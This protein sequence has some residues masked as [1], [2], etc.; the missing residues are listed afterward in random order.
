M[1]KIFFF[2]LAAA[3][4][5][6]V[7][8]QSANSFTGRI[9]DNKSGEPI[10]G[11]TVT[12]PDLKLKL[13]SDMLGNFSFPAGYKGQHMVEFSGLGYQTQSIKVDFNVKNLLSV[14]LGA[15]HVSLDEIIVTT[16]IVSSSSRRNSTSITVVDKQQL[17]EP[18]TNIIDALAK[19]APGVAAIT[20]GSS[21]AKPVIRGLSSNRVVTINNGI[22]QQGNQW[23]DEHG[24]EVDQYGA[25]RVEILRGAASLMYGSDA[26]GGVI[27]FLEPLVPENG[28]IKGELLSNYSTNAGLTS[29]SAMLTGNRNG[30]VWRGRGTYKNA[31]SFKT[32]RGYFPNSGFNETNISA[33]LGLNKSWGYSHINASFF[34]N[35]IGFY[36]P[37]FDAQ[38]NY[39]DADGMPFTRPDY[40]NRRLA[41]P[42]QDIRHYKLSWNNQLH[43]NAGTLKLDM[44]YQNNQRREMDNP[45]PNLFLDL[46]TF[47]MDAKYSLNEM[48]GWQPVFGVS[49]DGSQNVNKGA[50]FLLPDY[51]SLGTGTFAYLKKSW[52]K[53]TANAGVRYDYRFTKGEPYIKEDEAFDR[54]KNDFSNVSFALGLTHQ[55]NPYLNVKMNIGNAFRSP[56]PAELSSNGEHEGTFRYEIGSPNLKPEKS[57]Q[58]DI[59][60]D[61][62]RGVFSGSLSVYT[63]FINDYIYISSKPGDETSSG[64]AIYRYGQVDAQLSGFEGD[65]NL[66]ILPVLTF[67]NLFSYTYAKNKTLD[68]PLPFIPAGRIKNGLKFSPSF[69][70][71]NGSY[72]K[73]GIDNFL[74]QNRVD[75]EFETAVAGYTLLNAAIGTGVKV[76]GLQLQL[77]VSGNNLLNKKYY[78][79]LSRLRPGRLDH[80]DLTLGVYNPGRNIIFGFISS[81]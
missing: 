43:F 27:N 44:G 34:R 15:A 63:N 73:V 62:N 42:K 51:H 49:I 39:I 22:K 67:E 71:W 79:A 77:Y 64:M 66:R 54:Y 57:Y 40:K 3:S 72:L 5:I 76:M 35:N 4:V 7:F 69:K 26:L 53:T 33:M 60:V 56:N 8:A 19:L 2:V 81:F 45:V 32:P 14:R 70:R 28:R 50:E 58:S 12:V 55:L 37:D 31:Y 30:F 18:A 24:I 65:F 29:S 10:A 6:D 59:S 47:T 17:L 9:L 74:K 68:R 13:V 48:Q 38:G 25:D 21:I 61:Y 52:L 46:H 75:T 1:K 78:D 80:K 16:G 36:E 11:I 23:G 41:F 20:T